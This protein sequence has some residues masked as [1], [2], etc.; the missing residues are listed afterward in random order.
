[1]GENS[2]EDKNEPSIEKSDNLVPQNIIE[3]NINDAAQNKIEASEKIT[4]NSDQTLPK[5]QQTSDDTVM[6]ELYQYTSNLCNKKRG[7]WVNWFTICALGFHVGA[8]YSFHAALV[9]IYLDDG[10]DV[11]YKMA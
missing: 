11:K 1:M 10:M 8:I 3:N 6:A 5:Q 4:N 7:Y 9:L 2:I